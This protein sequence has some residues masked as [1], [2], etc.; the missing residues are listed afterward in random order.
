MC[1]VFGEIFVHVFL[2]ILGWNCCVGVIE[3]MIVGLLTIV[4]IDKTRLLAYRVKKRGVV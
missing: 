4:P 1:F 2:N 3:T